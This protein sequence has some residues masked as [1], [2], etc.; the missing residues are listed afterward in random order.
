MG[1][2]ETI[3]AEGVAGGNTF[4][5]T[6]KGIKMPDGSKAILE[7]FNDITEIEKAEEDMRLFRSIIDSST[8]EIFIID[9]KTAKFIDVSKAACTNLGYTQEELLKLGPK[10]IVAKFP[11]GK[12]WRQ[13]LKLIKQRHNLIADGEH[14]R[15]DRSKYLIEVNISYVPIKN[16]EYMIAIIRDMT[17]RKKK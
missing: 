8:D 17:K 4:L 12:S 3:K 2:I 7:I 6:H 11:G 1:T 16:K 13:L 5:I 10:D 15:K 9:I 14:I